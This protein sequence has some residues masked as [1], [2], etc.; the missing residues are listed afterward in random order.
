[1]RRLKSKISK[2]NEKVK[3]EKRPSEQE[4]SLRGEK[5]SPQVF[6]IYNSFSDMIKRELW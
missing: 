3:E 5:N 6:S 4:S 2:D 1:M